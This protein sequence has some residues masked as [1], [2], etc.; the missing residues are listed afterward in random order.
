M[1]FAL[2]PAWLTLFE[3]VK[4]VLSFNQCLNPLFG[5]AIVSNI[6]LKFK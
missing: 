6:K 2:E 5:A 1:S 3:A 4:P